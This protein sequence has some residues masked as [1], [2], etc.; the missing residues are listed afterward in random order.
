MVDLSAR[1]D[2]FVSGL[3]ENGGW[4]RREAEEHFDQFSAVFEIRDAATFV[5]CEA[6][7]L[8]KRYPRVMVAP[9]LYQIREGLLY[10]IDE[11]EQIL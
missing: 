3:V 6:R 5:L 10:Q 8:R 1:R 4:E 2:V 7:R 9:L 11:G